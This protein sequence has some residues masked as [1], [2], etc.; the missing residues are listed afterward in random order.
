M[1]L[2]ALASA[3]DFPTGSW[4][5][6]GIS[7]GLCEMDMLLLASQQ[8]CEILAGIETPAPVGDSAGVGMGESTH[9]SLERDASPEGSWRGACSLGSFSPV[10]SHAD[11]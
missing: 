9:S 5:K 11:G 6:S 3:V 10:Q 2:G 7:L 8:G 1:A 4:G